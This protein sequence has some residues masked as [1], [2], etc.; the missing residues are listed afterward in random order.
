MDVSRREPDTITHEAPTNRASHDLGHVY[1]CCDPDRALCG[2]DISAYTVQEVAD[3]DL[4][5]VCCHLDPVPCRR[6][7]Q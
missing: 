3:E 1:C 5:V 7:G 6:C 4:C 2:L